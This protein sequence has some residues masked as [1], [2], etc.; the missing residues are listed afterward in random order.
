MKVNPQAILAFALAILGLGLFADAQ[1]PVKVTGYGY[2]G[3]VLYG[4][5]TV[6]NYAY[7]KTVTVN[8]ADLASSWSYTCAASYS[9]G[10]NSANY[11]FWVFSCNV[12]SAGVSQFYISYVTNGNTYYDNNGGYGVNYKVTQPTTTTT[13]ASSSPTNT[14][15][16][17]PTATASAA[18]PP[19]P[20]PG[21]KPI[22]FSQDITTWLT[23]AVPN[24]QSYLLANIN[25]AGTL[26]GVV[27]AAPKAQPTSQNYFFHWI[28]DASLVMDVVRQWYDQTKSSVYQQLFFD[29]RDF[30]HKIQIINALTGLGE[31]KFNVD[32]T[33]FTGGWCRPQNDGPA[34]RASAF[35][36]FS[37]SY[38]S[39]GGT[40]ATVVDMWNGTNSVIKPDLEYISQSTNYLDTNGCDLW[41]EQRGLHLFTM[42]AQRRAL[43]EGAA[44]AQSVVNDQG[45]GTFYKQQAQA[46]ESKISSSFFSTSTN[47][48]Y[49]TLSGRQLDSAIPLAII[50]GY[51][52]DGF[53]P[54]TSDQVL[55]SL[56]KFAQGFQT[57]YTLNQASLIDSASG[58]SM[59]YAIGRY[60]GDTYDGK[61]NSKGNPWYLTTL[62]FAELY[63][64]AAKLYIDGGSIAVTSLNLP[65]FTGARPSGAGVTV[66]LS[67]GSTYAKG[68]AQFDAIIAGVVSLAE[69]YVRRVK[70][71]VSADNHINEQYNRDT[72]V[73]QGVDNLTWSYAALTTTYNARQALVNTGYLA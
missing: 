33:D 20:P 28:R 44:F 49:T 48:L 51:N 17:S 5:I 4:N 50:H 27:V 15:S 29:H 7:T 63:Y 72:G 70:H 8:Y 3:N 64:R 21:S 54:P 12:G 58:L 73:A 37:K 1:T 53:Y 2:I 62:V 23:A 46:I 55:V 25:A 16:A 14:A 32:G 61:G 45:A 56:Y 68:S 60:Y 34:F 66:S 47:T 22:G 24:A 42:M 39:N 57:E 59:S 40:L 9:S 67:A 19:P 13:R 35:I 52:D 43:L 71:H 30:T 38:L 65:F 10:P 69:T 26:A 41:E 36:R 6:Y 31:A 18:P 11:E